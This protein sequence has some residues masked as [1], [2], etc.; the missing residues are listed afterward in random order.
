MSEVIEAQEQTLADLLP[1]GEELRTA[2]G[3]SDEVEIRSESERLIGARIVAWDTPS[4]TPVGLE[5][6]RP[7]AFKHVDPRRVVLRLEHQDPPAGRGELLEE[8][9]DGAYMVFRVSKTLRGDEILTLAKDGVT[10]SVSLSYYPPGSLGQ[11]SHEGGKRAVAITKADLREVST[12]W[13]PMH[14]RTDVLFVRSEPD[15]STPSTEEIA[16]VSENIQAE[17]PAFDYDAIAGK[18]TDLQKRAL[19]EIG[20]RLDKMEERYRGDFAVPSAVERPKP[21]LAHWASVAVRQLRGMPISKQELQERA[22]DDILTP[23]NPGLVPDALRNDLLIGVVNRRRPFLTSTTQIVAPESG[24]NITVPVLSQRS[25][26]DTQATQKTE[27]DSTA[28]KVTTK[29]F[30]AVSVFGGADVA[31]QM[32]RRAEPYFMDLLMRDLGHAY[33]RKSD[34]LA[35][36]ALF[37]EGTTPGTANIDPENLSIGEAWENCMSATDEPP[38]TIWLSAKA[39]S[40]FIDAKNDGTNAPLYFNLNAAITAGGGPGGSVSA[41]R[42][43]YVPALDATGVDVMVGPSSGF[44]WAEDG[45]IELS[46]D[47]PAKAGRDIALGGILFY[48]PRYASAFTTYDLGS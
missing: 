45:N 19:D 6:F 43:I 34:A 5:S 2:A 20:E 42:P 13:K 38:D 44:A 41:L 15:P 28:M 37:T 3:S 23:D 24:M 14:Q 21:T 25:T 47:V 48:V 16:P 36:T 30:A 7:G 11:I 9:A 12:T 33:A 39:V 4:D 18:L 40:A 26:V 10:P 1:A 35:L 22:L 8:R 29:D 31:I 27:I 32:I 17:A 46:V